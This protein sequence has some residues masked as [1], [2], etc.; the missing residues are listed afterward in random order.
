MAL[1][2]AFSLAFAYIRYTHELY[3]VETSFL[4]KEDSAM[5]TASD[6]LYE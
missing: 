1:L 3:N 4:I 6:L 2:L 5:P